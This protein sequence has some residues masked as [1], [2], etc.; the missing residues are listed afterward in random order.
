MLTIVFNNAT[1]LLRSFDAWG[2]RV[3]QINMGGHEVHRTRFGG[4]V[5]LV[6]FATITAF[7]ISRVIKMTKKEDPSVFQVDRGLD[8]L[9]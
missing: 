6:V 9:G 7:T 3:P 5:G 1:N 4:C 8:L 2:S